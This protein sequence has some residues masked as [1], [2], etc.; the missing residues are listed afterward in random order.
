MSN[1]TI[2][3]IQGA[4]K[5]LNHYNI[6]QRL[7]ISEIPTK[8]SL[9]QNQA[10]PIYKLT[11]QVLQADGYTSEQNTPKSDSRMNTSHNYVAP[12]HTTYELPN[13]TKIVDVSVPVKRHPKKK[14]NSDTENNKI[15]ISEEGENGVYDVPSDVKEENIANYNN[16]STI[17]GDDIT[18][19]LRRYRKHEAFRI[20]PDFHDAQ[21]ITHPGEL[22]KC[23]GTS[24]TYRKNETYIAHSPYHNYTTSLRRNVCGLRGEPTTWNNVFRYVLNEYISKTYVA[25]DGKGYA[26]NGTCL[27]IRLSHC[28]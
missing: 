11:L 22:K 26:H 18:E 23:S 15:T 16:T 19:H 12:V 17:N 24:T 2:L 4:S 6:L 25:P 20:K 8:L 10:K 13:N 28:C 21:L 3:Q 14:L 7:I 1:K 9:A 27:L 5:F